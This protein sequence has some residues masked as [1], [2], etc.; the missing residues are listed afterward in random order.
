M[1]EHADVIVVGA[2]IY[3]LSAA[4]ELERRG[5]SVL[6]VDPGPL[7]HPLASSTDIS[8]V[9]RMEYGADAAYLRL[10]ALAREGWLRW[11]RDFGDTLY[12]ED[13]LLVLAAGEMQP[14]GFEYDSYHELLRHGF[15]PERLDA[16]QLRRR[17]PAWNASQYPDGFTH[18]RA[19]YAESGRVIEALAEQAR[20]QGVAL[21]LGP[22]VA[23]LVHDEHRVTGVRTRDGVQIAARY[24]VAAA[25]VWTPLLVPEL[26]RAIRIVGQPIFHLA[27]AEPRLYS[28]P[29]FQTFT[30]DITNTGWYGFALHPRT[31]IVKIAN[32]GIGKPVHP[33]DDERVV[34]Q[35]DLAR[36]RRF[37]AR[38]LPGLADAPVVYTRLCLYCDT[39]DGHFWIDRAPHLEGLVVATG[40]SGHGFKFGPVLGGLIADALERF[41]QPELERFRWRVM[42]DDTEAEE[43]ARC[44]RG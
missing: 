1:K 18:A 35:A 43:A 30:A 44:W 3:G 25:G 10:A 24:V 38:S 20:R 5:Y 28:P 42:T 15:T 12:H 33:A 8:K 7:P 21:A 14:G 2:G 37:V 11:N 40:G 29:L 36:L 6:V 27:C 32:H 22:R 39:L 31:G 16:K 23:S 17:F 9:V 41:E 13:G 34:G 19:G 4:L 26:Q